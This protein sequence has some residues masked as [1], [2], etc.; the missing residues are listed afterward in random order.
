MDHPGGAMY[1]TLRGT[2]GGSSA[3]GAKD[4]ER[5][6]TRARR[7]PGTVLALGCGPLLHRR[8]VGV[9]RRRPAALRDGCAGHQPLAYGFLDEVY[10][11]T[12]AVVRVLGGWWADR[13]GHAKRVA[14]V[15]YGVSAL[16]RIALLP[17]T[18]FAAITGVVA[19]DRLGKGL[20][21]G[22]R[23][24]LIADASPPDQLSRN[25]GVHRAMD[26]AGALIGPLAAFALLAAIP[27][28]LG[29]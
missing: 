23:D 24:A 18:G 29:G 19:L 27:I 14:L 25:F 21:T 26:T 1:V 12:S 5:T 20:R 13:T 11:G 9:R 3:P 8:L 15:G 2:P 10:Q 4:P 16:S 28:G 7:I 17:A 22:P 6:R